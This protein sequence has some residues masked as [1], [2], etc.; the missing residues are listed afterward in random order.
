[1]SSPI[2]PNLKTEWFPV[3]LLAIAVVLSCLF[4][5]LLPERVASHW[6]FSGQ[7]DG[8]S[9]KNFHTFFFPLLLIG[10]YILFLVLPY[11]DPK[12]ER[13]QE[14][15]PIYK[16]FRNLILLVLLVIYLAASLYNIGW[17]INIG[18]VVALAIGILMIVLGNYLGK[19]KNNWF[20]GIRT[21]WTLSSENV[22]NKT[23]RL[24]GW[25]FMLFGLIIIV[26]PWLPEIVATVAFVFGIAL[27]LIGTT[28]YSYWLYRKERKK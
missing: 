1:M 6:N 26:A 18:V 8:W 25:L 24:G 17:P 21:P 20:L 27:L 9:S 23:H 11:L 2:K 10:M 7:V 13:Y 22:W 12:R 15:L 16:I 4:H 5:P 14:F 3:L 19:I 28:V